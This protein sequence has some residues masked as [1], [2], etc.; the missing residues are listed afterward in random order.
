MPNMRVTTV[1][2][3][4]GRKFV[5]TMTAEEVPEYLANFDMTL[6]RSYTVEEIPEISALAK[7]VEKLDNKRPDSRGYVTNLP[8]LRDIMLELSDLV[9]LNVFHNG[10]RGDEID[11]EI[12]FGFALERNLL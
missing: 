1:P 7:M 4:T 11:V 6:L 10:N 3:S 5:T 2:K 12:K 8:E 9:P